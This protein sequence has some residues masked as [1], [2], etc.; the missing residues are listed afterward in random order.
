[1][2]G[3]VLLDPGD[4]LLDGRRL[5]QPGQLRRQVALKGGAAGFCPLG[6]FAMN[7]VG[8]RS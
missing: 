2:A 7:I 4:D 5:G 6:E 3:G 8:G 1:M